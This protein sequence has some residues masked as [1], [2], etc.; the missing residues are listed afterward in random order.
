MQLFNNE[1]M[2]VELE[3]LDN[4]EC[5]LIFLVDQSY[6]DEVDLVKFINIFKHTLVDEMYN[7]V[8]TGVPK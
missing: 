3:T 7:A 5:K 4:G 6:M 1:Y 8:E 2:N